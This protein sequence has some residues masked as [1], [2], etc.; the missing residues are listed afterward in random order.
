MQLGSITGSWK[1]TKL[2]CIHN[3]EKPI[4]MI[5]KAGPSSLFYACPKYDLESLEEGER[6]CNNRLNMIDFT[7]MLDHFNDIL[8]EAEMN[9]VQKDLTNMV[10][11]DRKGTVYK[12]LKHTP[13]CLEI[14]MI[15]QRAIRS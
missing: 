6:R 14:G 3:H 10:W 15:N 4:E 9:D 12:V 13:E 7:N 1:A 5:I 2:Y 11:K 8:V